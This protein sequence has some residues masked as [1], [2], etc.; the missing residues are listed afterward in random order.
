MP[1]ISSILSLKKRNRAMM[2]YKARSRTKQIIEQREEARHSYDAPIDEIQI[3]YR[4]I[5]LM[6]GDY[7]I[8]FNFPT[9]K[10]EGEP[11]EITVWKGDRQPEKTEE[12]FFC[13]NTIEPTAK[14]LQ[15]ALDYVLA[16]TERDNEE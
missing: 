2:P 7:T 1:V 10:T 15:Q 13:K 5:A 8:C 16:R 6:I 3:N 12:A 9:E 14:A 11:E 4:E